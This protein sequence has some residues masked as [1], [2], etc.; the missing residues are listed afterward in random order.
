MSSRTK[1]LLALALFI[2]IALVILFELL[3]ASGS[4]PFTGPSRQLQAIVPDAVSLAPAA[5]VRVAGIRIGRVEKIAVRGGDA[6]ILIGLDGNAP[7]IFSDAT[8]DVRTRT[9]VGE[10]YVQINPGTPSAGQ[11]APGTVLGPS[12]AVQA[13]QFDDVASLFSPPTRNEL[14]DN[15]ATLAS[16][17]SDRH[18]RQLGRLIGGLSLASGNLTPVLDNVAAQRGQLAE[19]IDQIGQVTRALGQRRQDIR[20]IATNATAALAAV[21]IERA[22]VEQVLKRLPGTLTQARTTTAKLASLAAVATTPVGDLRVALATLAP[23]IDQLA[24]TANAGRHALAELNAFAPH[25]AR[26]LTRLTHVAPTVTCTLPRLEQILSQANPMLA[27]LRPYTPELGAFFGNLG[28]IVSIGD[29]LGRLAR[30]VEVVSASTLA[31]SPPAVVELYQRLKDIGAVQFLTGRHGINPY[32]KPGT[33][34]N[35]DPFTGKYPRIQPAPI[36]KR[37]GTCD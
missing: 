35:P 20:L 23:T 8:V 21:G 10:N 3:G 6:V 32:P 24:P 27:Y 25:G 7:P 13:T 28:S 19:L 2:P 37:R 17:L 34:A 30:M 14:R 26:L 33:I 29:T 16:A 36:P 18:A 9:V 4:V 15:L 11:L 31:A 5:E 12:H 22:D 1:D